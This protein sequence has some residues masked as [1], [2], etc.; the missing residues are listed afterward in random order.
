MKKNQLGAK[1]IV[2]HDLVVLSNFIH[3][4]SDLPKGQQLKAVIRDLGGNSSLVQK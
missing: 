4:G 2:L 1:V 3:R